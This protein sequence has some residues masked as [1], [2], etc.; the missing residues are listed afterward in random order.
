MRHHVIQ[1]IDHLTNGALR[2]ECHLPATIP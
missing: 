1:L 2:D